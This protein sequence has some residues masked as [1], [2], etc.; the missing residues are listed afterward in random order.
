[1]GKLFFYLL[2]IS[3]IVFL[4][5]F[6]VYIETD[7]HYDMNRRKLAFAVFAYKIIPII[8]GYAA[9]YKGGIALHLSEK[10]A[11]LIPYSQ[12]ESERKRFSFIRTFRLKTFILTTESGAE[13]LPLTAVAHAALRS[14]FFI[15]G[16]DKKGIE[17]NL[18]LTDGDT[19]KISFNCLVRFN[20]YI[21]LKNFLKFSKEQI[22]IL[23]RKIKK[24][25]L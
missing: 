20:L 1:M 6:P 16:G 4:L 7:A 2:A 18:W 22:K 14:F 3:G 15:Q 9:T 5:F 10:K 19:L 17:N 25:A 12:M 11:V 21:L 24:S 13:Y 23:C 8:K